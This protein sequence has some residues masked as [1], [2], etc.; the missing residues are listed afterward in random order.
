LGRKRQVIRRAIEWASGLGPELPCLRGE[1]LWEAICRNLD[2]T[3]ARNREAP[4]SRLGLRG[5]KQVVDVPVQRAGLH[6]ETLGGTFNRKV[7]PGERLQQKPRG[8]AV[9]EVKASA[10][11]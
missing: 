2:I 7:S 1:R 4:D 9:F 8:N 3:F 11:G 5:Q 10:G 6:L